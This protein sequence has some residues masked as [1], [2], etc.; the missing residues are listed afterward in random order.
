M[1][2]S[3]KTEPTL[4]ATEGMASFFAREISQAV[5][6]QNAR[7]GEFAQSYV[8]NLLAD[9]SKSSTLHQN[10]D[11]E[12]LA[13][14][15][16]KSHNASAEERVRSLRRLGDLALCVAGFFADSLNR[17]LVDVDYYID[18]GGGAY[19]TLASIFEQR[20]EAAV[21]SSLY[22]ELG[23]KFATLVEVLNEVSEGSSL[24]DQSMLRLYDRWLKTGSERMQR[25][26][27]DK[28]ILPNRTVPRTCQ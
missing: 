18:M 13:M 19:G 4:I 1:T 6:K 22:D 21:F 2:D 15:Y 10:G 9:F 27:S 5:H 7:V 14:L 25:M 26:L 28:G 16:L 23:T 17:K 11:N 12:T 3:P 8:V 20:R 24:R